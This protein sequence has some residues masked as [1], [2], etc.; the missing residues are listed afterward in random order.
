MECPFG[1]E[2]PS[3][4]CFLVWTGGEPLTGTK[5]ASMFWNLLAL[6]KT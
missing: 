6:A 2:N 1:G 3:E 5:A 4:A